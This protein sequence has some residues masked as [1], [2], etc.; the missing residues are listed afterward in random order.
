MVHLR[1]HTGGRNIETQLAEKHWCTHKGGIALEKTLCKTSTEGP[2]F[3]DIPWGELRGT[4]L[5]TPLVKAVGRHTSGLGKLGDRTWG[6]HSDEP[7]G[8]PPGG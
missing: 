7:L 5:K 3:R 4:L 1:D 6:T 8:E 2:P